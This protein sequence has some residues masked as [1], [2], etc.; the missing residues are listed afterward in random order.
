MRQALYRKWRPRTFDEVCGQEHITSILKYECA[1][2]AFSHAYLFCGTRGTG[3][4]TC[5]KILAKAVNCLSPVDGSPCGKCAACLAIDSG[6]ATDVIEMDAASNNGVDNIR[7]IRDEVVYSPSMLKYKVYI[8]D[9][10]HMLS[11]SAF[12]ALLKTLE[13]PPSHVIFILATTEL[14]KLPSTIISRCRRFDFRRIATPT[15][16]ARLSE[17]AEKEGIKLESDAAF[18]L[19]KL[20]EG[21]MRDALSLLDLCAGEGKTITA[22]LAS[23]VVG[24]TG[25][26]KIASLVSALSAEDIETVFST[27]AEVSASSQDISVFWQELLAFYRDMLVIKT[28]KNAQRY[29][30]LTENETAEVEKCAALFTKEKLISH[31][32]LIEGA[33]GEMLRASGAKRLIC[34]MTLVKMCDTELDS[35]PEALGARLAKLEDRLDAGNF[36]APK[37]TSAENGATGE[38]LKIH[39]V[40]VGAKREV[41]R[42]R[43]ADAGGER[44]KEHAPSGA[45]GVKKLLPYWPEVIE[46]VCGDDPSLAGFLRNSKT[47]KN[48]S[49]AIVLRLD[50][51]FAASMIKARKTAAENMLAVISGFEKR[52]L[53]PSELIIEVSHANDIVDEGRAGI[54]EIMNDAD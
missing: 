53:A 45:S 29:L 35:S 39:D 23:E 44:A 38:V 33:L 36:T 1:S 14:H 30:D 8:V 52:K 11:V 3:K 5:A 19:A 7:D 42:E 15:I 48:E 16:A 40:D 28:S 10:V 6:S 24:V 50:S 51:E 26:D 54:E 46:R 17:V 9:E 32:R 20:A 43:P 12:N 2:G 21:G 34:E 41:P 31:C 27:V 25:R 22:E 4:T 18:L 37:R 47:Y 49:G 13:E